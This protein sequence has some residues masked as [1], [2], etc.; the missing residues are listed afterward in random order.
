MNFQFIV[1]QI[2][3]Q[4]LGWHNYF[5]EQDEIITLLYTQAAYNYVLIAWNMN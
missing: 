1:W 2:L 4:I 3:W 5:V